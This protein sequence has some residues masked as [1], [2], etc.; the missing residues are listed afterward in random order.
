MRNLLTSKKKLKPE[1]IF[2]PFYSNNNCLSFVLM[3]ESAN[4]SLAQEDS[5]V[6]EIPFSDEL[7]SHTRIINTIH[8]WQDKKPKEK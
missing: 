4:D 1:L 5:L 7:Q 8:T 2:P 6:F 3:K